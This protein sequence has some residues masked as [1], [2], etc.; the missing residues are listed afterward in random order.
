MNVNDVMKYGHQTV[1][2]ATEGLEE[3]A[4]RMP[5]ACGVW[6]VKDIVAHLTSFEYLLIDVLKSLD[7]EGPTPTLDSFMQDMMR[8]NDD[9]VLKRRDHS[10]SETMAEYEAAYTRSVEMLA[11]VPEEMLRQNGILT[12]YG[13]EYD[14]EDFIVYTFYGHKREHCA[15]IGVFRDELNMVT[16]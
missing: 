2:D 9:E 3:T 7:G 8:F 15:Q 6:S 1:L 14:L 13:E 16:S 4:W 10:V 11:R 12:W 5:G